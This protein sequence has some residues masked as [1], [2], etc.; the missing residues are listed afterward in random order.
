MTH[1][2]VHLD[3]SILDID[4]WLPE[5]AIDNI[6][7]L[8]MQQEEETT[9]SKINIT[10]PINKDL[11][12]EIRNVSWKEPKKRQDLLNKI[13]HNLWTYAEGDR[14]TPEQADFASVLQFM[15]N[16][17]YYQP[18]EQLSL[19]DWL[20][21]EIVDALGEYD[22][23]TIEHSANLNNMAWLLF[24]RANM[25]GSYTCNTVK[26]RKW[27]ATYASELAETEIESK[28][29]PILDPELYQVE[30]IIY[31]T[32]RL[33]NSSLLQDIIDD[34]SETPLKE[35]LNEHLTN[36]DNMEEITDVLNGN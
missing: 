25:D 15:S 4:S 29:E 8:I 23:D 17:E 33:F 20:V 1:K 19:A 18:V 26:A 13:S 28:W 16:S 31:L 7:Q 5:N 21:S 35:R 6:V 34:E 14:P 11:F 36:M 12:E 9:M 24:E 3:D 10:L 22:N 27:I 2:D 30:M 32:D